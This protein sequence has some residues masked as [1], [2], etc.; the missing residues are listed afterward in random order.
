MLDGR[1]IKDGALRRCWVDNDDSKI[2]P[3]WRRKVRRILN[4]LDVAASPQELDL[5]SF[6]FHPLTG[7][8]KGTFSVLVSRNWRITFKWSPA[9][10]P[11]DVDMEDYHGR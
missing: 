2:R 3:D 7:D 5:P 8:R 11:Y 10:H 9:G 4:A 6:N 1:W